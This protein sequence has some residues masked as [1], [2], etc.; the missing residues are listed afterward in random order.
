[1]QKTILPLFLLFF[2]QASFAQVNDSVV[3]KTATG[4]ISGTITVPVKKFKGAIVILVPGSGPTDRDGNN[5][6]LLNANLRILSDSLAKY[7]IASLRFDKRGIGASKKAAPDETHLRFDDYVKDVRDW[8]TMLAKDKR[9]TKVFIAGHSEGSLVGMI[10]AQKAK[11]AGYISIAGAGMPADQLIMEQL[12]ANP[13]VPKEFIDSS[14]YIFS[15]IKEKGSYSNVPSGFY[16]S[17]FRSSVQPYL[18]SWVRYDPALEIS[19]VKAP[20]L[21]IQGARDIQVDTAQVSL[22][23]A[24]SPDARVI[25]VSEMNHVFRDVETDDKNANIATYYSDKT[26]IDRMLIR[27]IVAFVRTFDHK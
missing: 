22:L 4:N 10:A 13:Q 6:I 20:V 26:P 9:F 25:I 21:L 23:A 14:T 17:L 8:V 2:A 3:L 18:A 15:Q 27:S 7:N 1:M 11:I 16:Q 24:A 5:G 19:K 12:S